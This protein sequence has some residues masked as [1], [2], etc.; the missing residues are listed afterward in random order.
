MLPYP[1]IQLTINY[2]KQI[3]EFQTLQTVLVFSEQRPK[4]YPRDAE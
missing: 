2:Q 4:Q 1:Q 3:K